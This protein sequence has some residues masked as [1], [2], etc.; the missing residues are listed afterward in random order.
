A[1]P[2]IKPF[3]PANTQATL[4]RDRV[5][6]GTLR[7]PLVLTAMIG[8][9][10]ATSASAAL[11][12]IRRDAREGEGALPRVRAGTLHVPA[13]TQ[14]GWT[15]VIVRL[16]APPLAAWSSDRA[17]ASATRAHVLDVTS[18]SSQAYLAKLARLQ[19]AAAAQVRAAVPAAQVQSRFSI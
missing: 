18:A 7:R 12:P 17:P 8:L 2:R 6:C 11:T 15:R 3:F 5:V 1:T 16:A 13:P 4:V 19:R 10:A 14:R 9:V